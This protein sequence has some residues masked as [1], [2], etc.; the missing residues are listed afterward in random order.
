MMR[1]SLLIILAATLAAPANGQSAPVLEHAIAAGQA[2]ER[3]DGYLGAVGDAS[4]QLRREISAVNIRRRNLY[5][6]LAEKRNVTADLVGM[7]TGCQLLTQLSIGEAYMLNDQ[8][9]RRRSTAQ[10]VPVP[11]YCR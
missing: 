3:F 10:A 9:W 5:L 6:E 4:P 11:D 2:G 8:V 1:G 7:A